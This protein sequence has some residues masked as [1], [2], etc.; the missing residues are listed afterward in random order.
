MQPQNI[1]FRSIIRSGSKALDT[2]NDWYF[3][4]HQKTCIVYVHFFTVVLVKKEGF[5]SGI[6]DQSGFFWDRHPRGMRQPYPTCV[7]NHQYPI[8]TYFVP[9]TILPYSILIKVEN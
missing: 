5:S 1:I 4:G 7:V 3:L 8:E 6:K 9:L 2:E